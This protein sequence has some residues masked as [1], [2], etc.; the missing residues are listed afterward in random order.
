[1]KRRKWLFAALLVLAVLSCLSGCS[2]KKTAV[3]TEKPNASVTYTAGAD[4]TGV[5]KSVDTVNQSVTFYN[6][7]SEEEATFLYSGATGITSKN[8]REMA[9]T[10]VLAGE[11]YDVCT[12]QDG[13]RLASM[14]E[15]SDVIELEDVTISV[16]SNEKRLTVDGVNYAY[17]DQLV[18]LSDGSAIDPMEI[19]SNDLVTFRG[20]KGQAYSVIVTCGHGYVRPTHY[21]DFVGGTVT[22]EGEAILPVSEGMLL[23]VPEGTQKLSMINGDLTGTASVE[24]RRGEVT[25]LNMSRFQTQVPNTA[26]VT[27]KIE[28]EGAELYVNG[29]LVDYGKAVRLK[30]GK[31][32]IKVVLEGY[33]EYSGIVDIQDPSPTVKINLA[34][35][36]AAVDEE[37]S[38]GDTSDDDSA[39]TDTSVSADE[40]TTESA[41]EVSEL[42]YDKEHKITVSAP[43]GAVVY[44]NGTY[45]GEVPCDFTKVLGSVTLTLSRD[46]YETKSYTIEIPDDSQD[47]SWSFPDL[48]KETQG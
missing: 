1:M 10:E 11:V 13:S 23:T 39:K 7:F 5:V 19:T 47:I 6:T 40:K 37:T 34:E 9:M 48:N 46:G 30:Y 38:K 8:G 16:N 27:F 21:A 31:H 24:V 4:F 26:R 32:S 36:T 35:E 2:R 17:S 15:S 33:S 45:K 25:E 14:Q 3:S 22:V 18:V 44:I 28:P 42:T 41:A 43:E 12:G 20:V 29:G